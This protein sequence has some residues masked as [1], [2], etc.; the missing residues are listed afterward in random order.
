MMVHIAWIVKYKDSVSLEGNTTLNNCYKKEWNN[1]DYFPHS[2][3]YVLSF[4]LIS[5]PNM[6]ASTGQGMGCSQKFLM[7]SLSHG[8]RNL[9]VLWPMV[10]KRVFL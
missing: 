9:N 7:H 3:Y 1:I 8:S 4:I 5:Y 10:K 6:G 2:L